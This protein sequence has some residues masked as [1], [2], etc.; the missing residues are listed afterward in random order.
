MCDYDKENDCYHPK[1]V[2]KEY[3]GYVY[4]YPVIGEI[5][6]NK[7]EMAGNFLMHDLK[8]IGL[9][10]FSRPG[11][12]RGFSLHLGGEKSFKGYLYSFSYSK[13]DSEAYYEEMINKRHVWDKDFI[14]ER[15]K[16]IK[17]TDTFTFDAL[18]LA[19]KRFGK[20]TTLAQMQRRM[21]AIGIHFTSSV[22]WKLSAKEQDE[23][24]DQFENVQKGQILSQIVCRSLGYGEKKLPTSTLTF[25]G[26]QLMIQTIQGGEPSIEGYDSGI[27]FYLED[28]PPSVGWSFDMARPQTVPDENGRVTAYDAV[29]KALAAFSPEAVAKRAALKEAVQQAVE[30]FRMRKVWVPNDGGPLRDGDRFFDMQ[31]EF[32]AALIKGDLAGAAV[33]DEKMIG[34]VGTDGYVDSNKARFVP[35]RPLMWYSSNRAILRIRQGRVEEAAFCMN[36]VARI[37]HTSGLDQDI[38]FMLDTLAENRGKHDIFSSPYEVACDYLMMAVL[39]QYEFLAMS[40]SFLWKART[41][42]TKLGNA[43]IAHFIDGLIGLQSSLIAAVFK[44]DDPEGA[45]LFSNFSES[46][47][48]IDLVVPDP[49]TPRKLEWP[50]AP[51]ARDHSSLTPE[52]R[53]EIFAPMAPRQQTL[54]DLRMISEH[55]PSFEYKDSEIDKLSRKSEVDVENLPNILQVMDIVCYEEE[56]YALRCRTRELTMRILEDPHDND[57]NLDRVVD[58]D[59][60]FIFLPKGIIHGLYYRGQ[61]KY[62]KKCRPS[63][64]RDR[65]DKEQFL[66][67]VKLCEFSILLRKHPSSQPFTEGYGTPLNDGRVESHE[68]LI[69][70]EALA[71]HYGILTE[72]IDLTADKWVT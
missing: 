31:E 27:R 29:L 61:A 49:E 28:N 10:P 5:M 64:F 57:G 51:F 62:F 14:V 41:I 54:E 30:P 56:K 50:K 25:E 8:V 33:L 2:A 48:G 32:A 63:L 53:K 16:E 4:A 21:N 11:S 52:Q 17:E 58:G 65:T 1:S 68:M 9:Q 71:Q 67:R 66:E 18:A 36:D 15:T 23:L 26:Q 59:G 20:G 40:L 46:L 72:Y 70:E 47:N 55:W 38:Y 44:E 3:V 12:Q 13:E 39:C 6:A 37:M 35:P 7:G 45:A 19:T 69:D 34:L 60:H 43:D 22:S 24:S 42:F